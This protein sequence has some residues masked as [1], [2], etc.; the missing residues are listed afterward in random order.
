MD[1]TLVVVDDND[2]I[3][4]YKPY[5]VCHKEGLRHR[6]SN[7]FIFKDKSL[8]ELVLFKRGPN[9]AAPN[10][11]GSTGGHLNKGQS[12]EECALKEVEEEAFHNLQFPKLDLNELGKI[13]IDEDI[14]NNF[15][16]AK[17]FYVIHEG[18]LNIDL[19]EGKEIKFY[20]VEFIKKDIKENPEKY[21]KFFRIIFA[22]VDSKLTL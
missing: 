1:E 7:T 17:I 16:W 6:S 15:E 20:P 22:F 2:E 8:K 3:V 4:G 11:L 10:Q 13:K 9:V 12:Y 14:P 5:S 19:Y 21:A 18:Q